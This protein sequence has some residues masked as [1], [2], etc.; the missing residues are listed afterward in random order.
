MP[1]GRRRLP[2]QMPSLSAYSA[3]ARPADQSAT[4]A[5]TLYA[6]RFRMPARNRT[7]PGIRLGGRGFQKIKKGLRETPVFDGNT[8]ICAPH[9]SVDFFVRCSM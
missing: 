1:N 8:K 6:D 4:L 7:S 2:V 3:S 5:K 9:K